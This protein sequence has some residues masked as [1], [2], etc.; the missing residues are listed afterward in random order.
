MDS[1]IHFEDFSKNFSK[2]VA[3]MRIRS[4][5]HIENKKN[6]IQKEKIQ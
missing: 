5:K 6:K 2:I 4:Y 3:F 1:H